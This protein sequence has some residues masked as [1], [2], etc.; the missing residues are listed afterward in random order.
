MLYILVISILFL[1]AG[2]GSAFLKLDGLQEVGNKS[3]ILGFSELDSAGRTRLFALLPPLHEAKLTNQILAV[4][5]LDRLLHDA[6]ADHANK[7]VD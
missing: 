2:A 7:L 1:V 6:M 5:A 4:L 3:D